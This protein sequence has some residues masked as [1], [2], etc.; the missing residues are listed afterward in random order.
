M[1]ITEKTD[2]IKFQTPYK[3]RLRD[4]TECMAMLLQL[5]KHNG[6]I[7]VWRRLDDVPRKQRYIDLDQV[8]VISEGSKA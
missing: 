8:T 7:Q 2:P 1:S 4:D 6:K 5:N 3:V